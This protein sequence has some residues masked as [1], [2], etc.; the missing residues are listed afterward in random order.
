MILELVDQIVHLMWE[1][2]GEHNDVHMKKSNTSVMQ[3]VFFPLKP[4]HLTDVPLKP[5]FPWFVA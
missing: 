5:D 3:D 1:G 4:Y 2:I